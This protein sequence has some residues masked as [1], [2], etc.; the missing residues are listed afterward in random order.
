MQVNIREINFLLLTPLES[1]I[2]S[3]VSHECKK[4]LEDYIQKGNNRIILNLSQVNF[5]DST[6]LGILIS[7]VKTIG[8]KGY[9]FIC[10][11][12]PS[13]KKL[14]KLVRVDEIFRVFYT[15]TEAIIELSKQQ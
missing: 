4:M 9:L 2:D 13:V 15:E 3:T 7:C 8:E 10:E 5:M 6:G 14:F 11:L 12:N 1:R